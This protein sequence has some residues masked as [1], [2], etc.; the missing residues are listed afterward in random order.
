MEA[1]NPDN[2]LNLDD[3]DSIT[4]FLRQRVS[5][6][7]TALRSAL[8]PIKVEALIGQAKSKWKEAHPGENVKNMMLPLIRLKVSQLG[9]E[10]LLWQKAPKLG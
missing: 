1:A 4:A 3:R 7:G 5:H 2:D 6:S 9:E 8:T 10:L